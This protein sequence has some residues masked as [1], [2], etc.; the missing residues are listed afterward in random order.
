[1]KNCL[2]MTS[3]SVGFG[4]GKC[5][6]IE[7]G[8]E[9][10]IIKRFER[11]WLDKVVKTLSCGCQVSTCWTKGNTCLDIKILNLCGYRINVKWVNSIISRANQ[12]CQQEVS[13]SRGSGDTQWWLL[14]S[15]LSQSG[16]NPCHIQPHSLRK[17][18]FNSKNLHLSRNHLTIVDNVLIRIN[19]LGDTSF[20]IQIGAWIKNVSVIDRWSAHHL[21]ELIWTEVD[22]DRDDS[23]GNCCSCELIKDKREYNEHSRATEWHGLVEFQGSCILFDDL[24]CAL[25]S[26]FAFF[27]TLD[28]HISANKRKWDKNRKNN[29]LSVTI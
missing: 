8:M 23:H 25:C 27:L 26:N 1:M 15:T 21:H 20:H 10:K 28:L 5:C 4:R 7:T 16:H 11:F 24:F 14:K 9:K 2:Q 22:E 17:F 19:L 18:N 29:K 12:I 3:G 6:K 13:P